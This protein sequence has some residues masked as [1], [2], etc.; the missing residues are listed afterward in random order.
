MARIKLALSIIVALLTGA[1]LLL[2]VL[3]TLAPELAARLRQ[4]HGRNS[5]HSV[6]NLSNDGSTEQPLTAIDHHSNYGPDE[7]SKTVV[8]GKM[9]WESVDWL[10]EL[11]Y[12][13]KAVY[14]VD[15]GQAALRVPKNKGN[16]AMVYLSYIIDHY[17]NLT[18]INIFIHAHRWA[19]HNN[20]LLDNDAVL[21]LRR[22]NSRQVLRDGY[23]NLRCQWHP[24]CTG[25]LNTQ[26][27]EEDSQR[28]E[29][30]LVRQAW[31][32][33]FPSHVLPDELAQACCSQFALSRERI[34]SLP[35]DEYARMREWLLGT[36]LRDS[37]SGRI[38]E[39]AWQYIWTGSAVLC[40][41]QHACF[42]G[43]YGA[44]F[45]SEEDFQGW[46]KMRQDLKRDEEE[47]ATLES[48][49]KESYG[50]P[51]T[52]DAHVSAD[53]RLTTLKMSVNVQWIS[54][55][56]KRDEAFKNGKEASFRARIGM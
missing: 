41:A 54:L 9:K 50:A 52:S 53:E 8:V 47:I 26:A 28:K 55:L 39:Y 20:D 27:E 38:F 12:I 46:F 37:M 10:D 49:A 22:L 43:L 30:V 35:R 2:Q 36:R 18:D 25:R 15:D 11:P 32:Q 13:R 21:M 56:Q 51:S 34:H 23:V 5:V 24:G 48:T 14:V 42:C 44:C 33:L 31:P 6:L 19:W 3:E 45:E 16:E 40:P 1:Y 17:E 7:Y 29:E 4:S